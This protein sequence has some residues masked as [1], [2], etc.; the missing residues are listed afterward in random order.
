MSLTHHRILDAWRTPAA[1][2]TVTLAVVLATAAGLVALSVRQPWTGLDLKPAE[3]RAGRVMVTG[4]GGPSA[5]VPGGTPLLRIGAADRW[6]TLDGADLSPE[7][8]TRFVA[9]EAFHA[10]LARQTELA[11]LL[12]SDEVCLESPSSQRWCL[13]PAPQRPMTDLPAMFWLQLVV[14]CLGATIGAAVWAY[15]RDDTAARWV[16]ISGLALLA[17]AGAAAV[18]GSR[19]LAID[20]ELFRGLHLVNGGGALA[21]C[22]A[23]AATLWH[24]PLRLGQAPVGRLL[25]AAYG[26]VFLGLLTG[27]AGNFDLALRL[28][29]LGGFALTAAF[30]LA[31]WRR[32]RQRPL[33]RAALRW[34]LLAW[35]GGGGAFLAVVFVPALLGHDVGNSQAPAFALFL[36]I[37]GGLALGVVRYRLFDL[38]RW[39]FT[40][41]TA[42]AGGVLFVLLDIS[43]VKILSLA[44]EQATLL[45]LLTVSWIYLPARQWLQHRMH[46]KRRRL[47]GALTALA[48]A[49][50]RSAGENWRE[51]IRALFSPLRILDAPAAPATP[52]ITDQGTALL[53]PG[54]AG[55]GALRLEFAD[56]GG[57]LFIPADVRLAESA[58]SI[59][60]RLH[61]YRAAVERGAQRERERIARTLHDDVGS[62]LL[63]V[64]HESNGPAQTAARRALAELRL[65]LQG[66]AAHGQALDDILGW[67]RG[68]LREHAD[69][70]GVELDWDAPPQFPDAS[71]DAHRSLLLLR[72]LREIIDLAA[73]TGQQAV[74]IVLQVR[75]HHLDIDGRL[76]LSEGCPVPETPLGTLRQRALALGLDLQTRAAGRQLILALRL[77]LSEGPG[78]A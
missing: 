64:L 58:H 12:A 32:S 72:S 52:E 33:E 76:T 67:C 40:A 45:A 35:L 8:D 1:R 62:A 7:P 55:T 70:I 57:R 27:L 3:E 71:L 29:V 49:P 51:A 69:A 26:L 17:S 20:G 61:A 41:W 37:Y 4:S 25:L 34:F 50:E 24:Y 5:Q 43:M 16:G 60:E 9:F 22:A 36:I 13:S 77:P 38:D 15:R 2:L 63:S 28:P 66:L 68:E 47:D 6:M 46:R 59:A 48:S 23:F 78:S 19:E 39:W 65:V 30:A 11:T 14:G 56:A 44:A 21:F 18:Y 75:D 10:F 53:V 54:L 42:A 73:S 74:R 31:Q